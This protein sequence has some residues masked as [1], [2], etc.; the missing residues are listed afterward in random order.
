MISS[1]TFVFLKESLL[2]FLKY[3]SY[4]WNSRQ[5]SFL[6]FNILMVIF[7][8]YWL[9]W[10]VCC[11]LYL[12]SSAGNVLFFSWCFQYFHL[13]LVLRNSIMMLLIIVFFTLCAWVFFFNFFYICGFIV[14]IKLEKC[15]SMVSLLFFPHSSLSGDPN[16]IHAKEWRHQNDRAEDSSHCSPTEINR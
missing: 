8:F 13:S 14:F 9:Q 10:S 4:V 2:L 1:S 16:V 3:V 11:P 12:W 15:P 5:S 7:L 6:H